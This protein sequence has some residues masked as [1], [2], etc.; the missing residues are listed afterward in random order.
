[1]VGASTTKA[2]T[3][4]PPVWWGEGADGALNYRRVLYERALDLEGPDAV[5]AE[6]MTSS[7]HPQTAVAPW[8]L[9]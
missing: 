3:T 4:L 2:L 7:E 6:R 9:R 1:M 5:P 8:A